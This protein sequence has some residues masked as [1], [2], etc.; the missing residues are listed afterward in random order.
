MNIRH[1]LILIVPV[2]CSSIFLTSTAEAATSG[3]TLTFA[4]NDSLQM[5]RHVRDTIRSEYKLAISLPT[6]VRLDKAIPKNTQLAIDL[7]VSKGGYGM[8]IFERT[9]GSN[10]SKYDMASLVGDMGTLRNLNSLA[11]PYDFC[12]MRRFTSHKTIKLVD[13]VT[14]ANYS[15]TKTFDNAVIWGN[16]HWKYIAEGQG[17]VYANKT[18][19][20]AKT[21]TG[22]VTKHGFPVHHASRGYVQALWSGNR[23]D[24]TIIWTYNNKQWY[25][26]SMETLSETIKTAKTVTVS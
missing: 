22:L 23:P 11:I 24:F 18:I 14:A 16:N 20:M 4:M 8:D 6:T 3:R 1:S 21:I 19:G 12:D 25:S 2:F 7:N 9:K 5:P 26:L 17:S 15:N 10:T 13:G